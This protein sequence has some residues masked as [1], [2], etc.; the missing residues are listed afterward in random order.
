MHRSAPATA[1]EKSPASALWSGRQAACSAVYSEACSANGS[2]YQAPSLLQRLA[3]PSGY[4]F[5]PRAKSHVLGS[6]G[7]HHAW[8]GNVLMVD[9]MVLCWTCDG[10]GST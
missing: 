8:S 5:W 1:T 3:L 7:L 2:G 4:S 6:R 9:L 10:P